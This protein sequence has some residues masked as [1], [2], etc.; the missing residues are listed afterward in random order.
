MNLYVDILVLL[1]VGGYLATMY[2]DLRPVYGTFRYWPSNLKYL[3]GTLGSALL[4]LVIAAF[5]MYYK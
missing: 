4:I 3:A 5:V 1:V 2:I